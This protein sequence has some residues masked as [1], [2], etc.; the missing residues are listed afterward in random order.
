MIKPINLN[1]YKENVGRV[2]SKR[3]FDKYCFIL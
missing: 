3:I 2:A 1:V